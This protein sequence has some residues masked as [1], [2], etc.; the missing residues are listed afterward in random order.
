MRY[1]SAVVIIF[2]FTSCSTYRDKLEDKEQT[3]ELQYITWA[4]DC[5]NWA[6]TH[7]LEKYKD[8]IGDTLASLSIYVE[9]ADSSL[10]LPVNIGYNGD[11]VRFTG[12]FYKE[13]GFP[14]NYK[15]AENPDKA[16][17]FR[18]T[19]YKVFKRNQENKTTTILYPK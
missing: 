12:R 10:R 19:Q 11:R 4:C 6:T 14:A 18:Y 13:K 5:A 8:N 7:D 9:A 17:V 1:L 2:L 15:S 3:V 16:R